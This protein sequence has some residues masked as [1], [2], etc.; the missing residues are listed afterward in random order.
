MTDSVP[1]APP[2]LTRCEILAELW[3]NHKTDANF[4]D[5][6][7]YNDLGLP[8]AYAIANNVVEPKPMAET[9]VNE[10]FDQ[11]CEE[12]GL[13]NDIN[14]VNLDQMLTWIVEDEDE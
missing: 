8:I 1:V 10:T 4:I 11:L 2:F 13:V 5:F 3:L 12:L 6:V 7:E 14:W 9:F